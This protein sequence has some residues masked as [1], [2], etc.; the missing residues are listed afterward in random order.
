[1]SFWGYGV[2]GYTVAFVINPG[3]AYWL[4]SSVEGTIHI[5]A[6]QTTV[7]AKASPSPLNDEFSDLSRITIEDNSGGSQLLY[8]GS[9]SAFANNFEMSNYELPPA[10]PDRNF[11]ARFTS[12]HVLQVYPD[13]LEKGK[14]YEYPIEIQSSSYPVTIRWD[15]RGKRIDRKFVLRTSNRG[16]MLAIADG[17][18]SISLT[19]PAI[20]QVEL[21][22]TEGMGIPTEFSLSQNYP[23]PFNPVTVIQY[24]LPGVERSGAT[25]YNV[26]LKIYDLLGQVVTT[27]VNETQEAGY[28]SV[29]FDASKM[30]SG[31]YFYW[32]TARRQDGG[33]VVPFTDV[34]KMLLIR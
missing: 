3:E 28:K 9:E 5:C 6:P 20:K 27:L 12:G 31:M 25:L 7:P 17:S 33:Q 16:Q 4:K 22:L 19:D 18:G 23:N 11:D 15:M 14:V 24:Q 30:P 13:I 34:K 2:V 21:R 29:S 1:M 32:M 10:A 26:S 8:I